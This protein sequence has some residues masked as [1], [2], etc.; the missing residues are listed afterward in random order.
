VAEDPGTPAAGAQAAGTQGMLA[1]GSRVAG[2]VIEEQIGAGGMAVVY[3]ARDEVLG[4][5]VAVK[6]LSP[7][8][9][10]DEEFRTRFLRES[11]AVASVDESHIVPVYGA[12]DAGGVLYIASRFVADGDL[13]RVQRAANGPLPPAQVADIVSQVASALDAAHAI[14]LVHRDVKPGNI[15]IERIPGRP[16]HAYLSDF[17]L[18]KSTSAGATGLT[19]TGRFMGT[20]DYCAPEQITGTA[21]DGRADQYSLACVAFSLLAGVVPFSRGDSLSRLFAHVNSPIPV[22][23]AIRPELPPALNGVLAKGMAK[24]P[25]ERYG[26]CAAFAS[27][28]RGALGV[29][30]GAAQG[31]SLPPQPPPIP[32]PAQGNLGYQQTVTAGGWQHP[33]VP[34]GPAGWP[35]PQAPAGPGAGYPQSPAAG[36]PQGQAGGYQQ[37][38]PVGFPQGPGGGYQQGPGAGY[39][40]SPPAGYPQGPGGMGMRGPG[41]AWPQAPGQ[42]QRPPR[43][44]T[45]LIVGGS[46]AAAAVLI[47]GVV[48]GITLTSNHGKTDGTQGS[49]TS[50]GATSPTAGG[51]ASSS[52]TAGQGD[53]TGTAVPVGTL[54]GPGLMRYAFFSADGNDVAA[55]GTKSDIY[56]FSAETMKRTQTLS[57]PDG[58]VAY[59]VSF[60]ADDKTLY[61]MDG[62]A[63]KLYVFDVAT[64]KAAHVYTYTGVSS[65]GYTHGGGVY[66]IETSS[67]GTVAEYEMATNKLYA[68]FPN[69]GKA[70]IAVAGVTTDSDGRYAL[71][72]DTDGMSYLVDAQ[73]KTVVGTFHYTYAGD[74]TIYPQLS[75][76]GNTVYVPG[77]SSAPAK[78]WDRATKSDITPTDSRW[79]ALDNGITFSTDSRFVLTSPSSATETVD[80]WNVAT[81]AHVI[82]LTVPGGANEGVEGIGP[83]ASELLS[84]GSLDINAGTFPKLNIWSIPS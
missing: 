44:H 62:T 69:P 70:P 68:Q 38:P 14:G 20:P 65:P 41:Q 75:L 56:V 84:T 83:G 13:S 61:A 42:G 33:S 71:V 37:S 28:L 55:A 25:A 82:T 5:L 8:L 40:Q 76:D 18:S 12:G 78:L 10:S 64:G 81:R 30:P 35:G 27:A 26:S 47:V 3:R 51:T 11:R 73:S 19:A 21:V 24:N 32:F 66:A 77:G 29:G 80:V 53:H 54:T 15:L 43:K 49:T 74:S 9:A 6:V 39:Q 16:E 48:L 17:G 31:T 7:G 50:A 60:S 46:A 72:S 23:T 22:V 4:R 52:S 63:G 1:P 36:F 34:P 58:D 79:P 57:V 67:S 2:Y 45:G 59:P